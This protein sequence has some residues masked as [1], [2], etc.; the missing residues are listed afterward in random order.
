MKEGYVG[1]TV[2]VKKM[3]EVQLLSDSLSKN[4]ATSN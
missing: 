4:I 2:N 3:N 1:R